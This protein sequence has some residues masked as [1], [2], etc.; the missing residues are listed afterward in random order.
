AFAYDEAAR[1]MYGPSAR[2]NLPNYSENTSSKVASSYDTAATCSYFESSEV[3][4]SKSG[5]DWFTPA[6][7]IYEEKSE[8]VNE[9][10]VM[11]KKSV[12]EVNDYDSC[13]G[14]P[15]D[16]FFD[17]DEFISVMDQ[18]AECNNE[19]KLD[20]NEIE[21]VFVQQDPYG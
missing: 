15:E 18:K 20:F 14:F 11:R 1:A 10:L 4:D 5:L 13:Q 19:N 7:S 3:Q 12:D 2:L 6:E 9:P 8:V 21:S 16:D 17:V